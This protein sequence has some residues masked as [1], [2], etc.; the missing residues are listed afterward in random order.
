MVTLPRA[1]RSPGQAAI[2][3]MAASRST[4]R[5]RAKA[6]SSSYTETIELENVVCGAHQRPF[7][8]DVLETAQQKLPEAARPLDLSDDPF[9]EPF[10]RR[11]GGRAGLREQLPGHAVDDRRVFRQRSSPDTGQAVPHVSASASRCTHRL[12]WRRSRSG[13]RP[14][15]SRRR[16]AARS[17]CRATAARS[18]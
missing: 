6:D 4:P 9:D 11:V 3:G 10:A 15:N 8:L 13:S 1:A 5:S 18:W 16:R 14:S 12:W 2:S 7:A 17:A